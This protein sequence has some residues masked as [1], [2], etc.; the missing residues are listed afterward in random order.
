MRAYKSKI[1]VRFGD[2]DMA[3]PVYLP[4]YVH[5]FATGLEDYLRSLGFPLEKVIK[6]VG[7]PPVKFHSQFK[8]S[9]FCGDLLA[10]Y[11]G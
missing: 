4:Q 2:T 11:S 1:R 6:E 7:L 3:G 10:S 9:A 8:S 5:Y